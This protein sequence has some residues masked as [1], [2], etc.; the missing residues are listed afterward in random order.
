MAELE[1]SV[2]GASRGSSA[3]EIAVVFLRGPA[4]SASIS[5]DGSDI[6]SCLTKLG[7][8]PDSG[9]LLE[10]D[11]KT[12]L[13]SA[14]PVDS[15][16]DESAISKDEAVDLRLFEQTF[17]SSLF[18]SLYSVKPESLA[19]ALARALESTKEISK[20]AQAELL[21]KIAFRKAQLDH[22]MMETMSDPSAAI[23]SKKS[24][25]GE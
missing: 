6:L 2:A 5:S 8:S 20:K 3:Q 19:E 13:H 16:F 15:D 11:W 23:E 4:W 9:S 25:A 18:Q 12:P 17:L 14:P 1:A 7:I 24:S 10:A 22:A 21:F